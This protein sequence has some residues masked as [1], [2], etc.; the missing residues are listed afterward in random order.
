M[1]LGDHT[2]VITRTPA[3]Q[4]LKEEDYGEGTPRSSGVH[5]TV[6]QVLEGANSVF[7]KLEQPSTKQLYTS[8]GATKSK[9]FA[10]GYMRG[11]AVIRHQHKAELQDLQQYVSLA[12]A[13]V[14]SNP[15]H[16]PK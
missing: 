3:S 5:Y 8:C 16:I 1:G 15:A 14:S 10:H 13:K 9:Y 7:G 4:V 2:V 12:E 6:T 11:R